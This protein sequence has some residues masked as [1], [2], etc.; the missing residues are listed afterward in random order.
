MG[1]VGLSFVVEP[2][3]LNTLIGNA[4][5]YPA[6]CPC[7]PFVVTAGLL[8]VRAMSWVDWLCGLEGPGTDA[9]LLVGE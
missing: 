5:L 2:S 1:C 3:T 4:S 6:G 8:V 9:E 7:L